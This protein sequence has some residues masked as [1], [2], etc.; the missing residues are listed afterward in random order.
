MK[1]FVLNAEIS[2]NQGSS[3][4]IWENIFANKE[5]GKYPP[6]HL[7]RFIARNFYNVSNRKE[8][9]ILELGFGTG[10]NLWFCAREGFRVNGI[11]F[12][13]SGIERFQKR[14]QDEN[15]SSF[16]GQIEQGD[17]LD[18]LDDFKDE[19]F[20]C[21]VDNY[22]LAYNDFE[23]TRQI[24]QKA[25]NKLKKGGKFLSVTPSIN[26]EGFIEDKS[27]GY[28]SCKPLSG[29]DA[30]TGVIRYCDEDD[31]AKLYGQN[32][33]KIT[34]LRQIIHKN[35]DKIENEL[36]IIEGVKNAN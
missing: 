8:I 16:I 17:Y 25:A 15:L 6:E 35:K 34:S 4:E 2:T 23:K 10:A 29:S 21:F 13:K 30:F 20:D 14:M 7:I 18:K 33:L 24:I 5:W 32:E 28:H 12:S 22:S 1:K 36:Y 31:I 27:L 19:S 26:N 9:N 3:E 11:E